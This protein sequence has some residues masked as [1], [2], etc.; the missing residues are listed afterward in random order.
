LGVGGIAGKHPHRHRPA[1]GCGQQADDELFLA[2]LAVAVIAEGGQ[3]V[4]DALEVGAGDIVEKQLRGRRAI[5]AAEQ[6]L[7]DR[8]LALGEPGEVG[9][10][11]VLVE[12]VEPED[13]ADRMPPGQAHGAEAGALIH[14]PGQDLPQR[15]SPLAVSAQYLG[16][17]ESVGD[18]VEAKHGAHAVAFDHGHVVHRAQHRQIAFMLEREL[19]GGDFLV[20]AVGEVGERALLDL[21]VFAVRMAQEM[22]GVGFAAL[23]GDGGVDMHSDYA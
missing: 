2:L 13:L 6:P 20:G 19:D 4:L 10:Q 9:I 22:A 21:A 3:Q 17:A 15:Q 23:V 11:M 5:A 7:F 18:G 16:D 12:G 14:E 1:I 8:G